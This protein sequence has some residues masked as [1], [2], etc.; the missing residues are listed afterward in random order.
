MLPGSTPAQ[1]HWSTFG[2]LV[3][4]HRAAS[5]AVD[6]TLAGIAQLVEQQSCKLLAGVQVLVSA[7]LLEYGFA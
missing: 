7:R 4:S 1:P 6:D 3:D 5:N 2:S